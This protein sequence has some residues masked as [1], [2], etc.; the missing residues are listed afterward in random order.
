MHFTL[1]GCFHNFRVKFFYHV[2]DTSAWY[3]ISGFRQLFCSRQF[4]LDLQLQRYSVFGAGFKILSFCGKW[5][6]KCHPRSCKYL[7][8]Y[9][10]WKSCLKYYLQEKIF[11]GFQEYSTNICFVSVSINSQMYTWLYPMYPNVHLYNH[12]IEYIYT[13]IIYIY[14]SYIYIYIIHIYNI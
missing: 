12:N 6:M 14:I 1:K 7:L 10:Y 13:Y 2:W 11:N 8:L 4:S 9:F 5:L 3:T